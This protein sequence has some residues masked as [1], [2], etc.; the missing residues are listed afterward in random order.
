MPESFFLGT[1][2]S[3]PK[4]TPPGFT[5]ARVIY[6]EVLPQPPS[7]S[8]PSMGESPSQTHESLSC[9]FPWNIGTKSWQPQTPLL[10]VTALSSPFPHPSVPCPTQCHLCPTAPRVGSR[11]ALQRT[12]KKLKWTLND[13]ARAGPSSR[14]PFLP[15][16]LHPFRETPS[17]PLDDPQKLWGCSRFWISPSSGSP[18]LPEGL[19]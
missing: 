16:P 18:C 5:R 7:S 12:K 1:Q 19:Q 8:P 4:A 13:G 9:H 10:S 6:M 14:L 15:Q 17:Q 3:F 2:G 11:D